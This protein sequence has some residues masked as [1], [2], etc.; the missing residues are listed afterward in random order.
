MSSCHVFHLILPRAGSCLELVLT[1]RFE[2]CNT[3]FKVAAKPVPFKVKAADFLTAPNWCAQVQPSR[4]CIQ[5][6]L[7]RLEEKLQ[8][9]VLNQTLYLLHSPELKVQQ[10]AATALAM[11]LKGDLKKA[12]VDRRGLEILTLMIKGY[13][14]NP[15]LQKQ[16]ASESPIKSRL[17]AGH[18]SCYKQSMF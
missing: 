10:R 4:D 2:E 1:S 7:K 6:T 14:D 8:G 12:F 18:N 3:S 15:F 13:P 9:P 11:L 16:A 5:K 17:S